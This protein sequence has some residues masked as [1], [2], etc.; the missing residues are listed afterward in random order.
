M[1]SHY[2]N[3]YHTDWDNFIP[4]IVFAYNT[5]IQESTMETPFV[6]L[7]GRDPLY[8]IDVLLQ[9]N[10]YPYLHMKDYKSLLIRKLRIAEKL[11]RN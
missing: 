8:P 9:S 10:N 3:E 4:K 2:V 5:S 1:M 6:L 7:Y 11:I